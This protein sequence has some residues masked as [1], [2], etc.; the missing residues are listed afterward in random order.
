MAEKKKREKEENNI[1]NLTGQNIQAAAEMVL[2]QAV[3]KV[4]NELMNHNVQKT[5]VILL[6]F[7]PQNVSLLEKWKSVINV[8][9][10]L[11]MRKTPAEHLISIGIPGTLSVYLQYAMNSQ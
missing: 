7:D 4:L 1:V 5:V 3:V 8:S 9:F 11:V 2:Y 6:V 10:H